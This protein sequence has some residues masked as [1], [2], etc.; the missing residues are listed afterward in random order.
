[1]VAG[2]TGSGKSSIVNAL[3]WA[4]APLPNVAI[5]GA[6]LKR[7]ELTPWAPRLT[8]LARDGGEVDAALVR[9]R[10]EIER[11]ERLLQ[12][13]GVRMWRGDFGPWLVV[14]VDEFAELAVAD[15]DRLIE[16]T[17]A[18]RSAESD[19][20]LNAMMKAAGHSLGLRSGILESFARK[21]RALGV[22][23]VISTQYPTSDVLDTQVRAQLAIRFMC[24]VASK[25]QV[26]VCLGTGAEDVV[27][28]R[29]LSPHQPGSFIVAGLEPHSFT[30]RASWISDDLVAARVAETAGRRVPGHVAFAADPATD[31]GETGAEPDGAVDHGVVFRGIT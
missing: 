26:R 23:M 20:A 10:A 4:L 18:A 27:D 11:R 5:V 24:R 3:L 7:I 19:K 15:L 30:A 1:L 13:A 29:D 16:A 22:T 28:P 12:G 9:L 17:Q 31:L 14:I 2:L 8:V 25:E 21:C 6:D